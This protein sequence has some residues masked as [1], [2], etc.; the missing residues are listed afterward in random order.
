MR[1]VETQSRQLRLFLHD[2]VCFLLREFANDDD[3]GDVDDHDC[4]DAD[5]FDFCCF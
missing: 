2:F 4:D 1:P 5:G 3:G